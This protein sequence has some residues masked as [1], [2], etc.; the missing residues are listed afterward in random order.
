MSEN[1]PGIPESPTQIG[2]DQWVEHAD[3]RIER[4]K[5]LGGLVI[6]IIRS[7]IDRYVSASWSDVFIFAILIIVLVF[8]PTGL[9]GMRVPEK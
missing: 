2:I 6:G 4:P 3:E 9:L 7:L 8:R 1:T 5:G